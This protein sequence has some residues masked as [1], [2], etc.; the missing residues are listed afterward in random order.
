MMD[1]EGVREN[2]SPLAFREKKS[3]IHSFNERLFTFTIDEDCFVCSAT[4][5]ADLIKTY[6]ATKNIRSISFVDRSRTRSVS[7]RS[8]RQSKGWK[9]SYRVES[10]VDAMICSCG[11]L[12][13]F[14]ITDAE[15]SNVFESCLLYNG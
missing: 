2:V 13:L 14:I 4:Q 15:F 7:V 3:D 9:F 10:V 1:I 8:D 5:G 12:C 6:G 11:C